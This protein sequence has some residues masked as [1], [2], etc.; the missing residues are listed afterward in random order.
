MRSNEEHMA[1]LEKL[2]INT[3]DM[4]IVNLYPFKQTIMKPGVDLQTCIENI[5]IDAHKYRMDGMMPSLRMI[6]LQPAAFICPSGNTGTGSPAL[7]ANAL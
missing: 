5:D 2:N 3:I 6:L 4:V 1:Q 7:L